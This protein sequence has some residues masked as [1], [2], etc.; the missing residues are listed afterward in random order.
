MNALGIQL[1][2]KR[3]EHE[4]G[5]RFITADSSPIRAAVVETD[6]EKMIALD[7]IAIARRAGKL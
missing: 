6:E 1:D 7:T 3:N 5:D 4:R 2:E